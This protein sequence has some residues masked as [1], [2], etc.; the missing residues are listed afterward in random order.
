MSQFPP[1]PGGAGV[2][3][4]QAPG[5]RLSDAERAPRKVLPAAV[6]VWTAAEVMHLVHWPP[7][8]WE[9]AL[10]SAAATAAAWGAAGRGR[11]PSWLPGWLAATGAWVT[12]ASAAG[13]LCWLPYVPLTAAWAA[14]AGVARWKAARHPSVTAARDHREAR[15]EWL[16]WR[17]RHWGL[18]G[19]HLLRHEQTRLGEVFEAST[20]GTGQRA[21]QLATQHLAELVAEDHDLPTAERVRVSVPRPGRIRISIRHEDP[22]EYQSPHPVLDDAPEIDLSGPY[23]ILEPAVIGADPETG[24]PLL[25]PLFD[26]FGSK[27]ISVVARRRSGKTVLLNCVSE[28]VTAAPD[29]LMIRINLSIKGTAEAARW[30]PS[31]HLTAFGTGT[32]P[33]KRAVRV[34][35]TVNKILEWRSRQYATTQ[36]APSR[37]DPGLVIMFDEVDSAMRYPAV[38][39][40]VDDIVTKGGEAGAT[41]VRLGQRGTADYSSA[42]TRSQDDVIV[43]GRVNRA[44][45]V[46]HAAGGLAMQLPDMSAYGEGAK[47]VWG[48]V[49]EE[50]CHLGRTFPL[51][52]ADSAR[53]AQE[54]AFSQPELPAACREYLG[55]DYEDLL[56][57]E[58]FAEWA[59]GRGRQGEPPV[60]AAAAAITAPPPAAPGAGGPGGDFARW[61]RELHDPEEDSM[62]PDARATIAG[63]DRKLEEIR[64][65]REET[66]ALPGPPDVP[67]EVLEAFHAERWRKVAEAAQIP[68]E[69][70]PD[71]L[72]MLREGTTAAQITEKFKITKWTARTWLERLR[73]EGAAR[74]VGER[75]TAKWVLAES[76]DGE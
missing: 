16:S 25:L 76:G 73:E 52:S 29:A 9:T 47:G 49:H 6:A 70:R 26:E 75:R 61:D 23:S 24:R 34:L 28:R 7:S 58:V 45:E 3:Q 48:I 56:A 44:G 27:N 63:V 55:D 32:E 64:R 50:G 11:A 59:R 21:S 40:E 4:P 1:E 38:R 22:W 57:T 72:E 46:H 30:G 5:L 51:E 10:T 33:L 20:K 43:V 39:K 69:A 37:E 17:A 36:Y 68:D 2:E 60:A 54:R 18:G 67:P 42:K 13:P 35:R 12:V 31:C 14:G 62:D 71:L 65:M 74:V 53:L 66:A 15:A 8:T 41:L 19:S